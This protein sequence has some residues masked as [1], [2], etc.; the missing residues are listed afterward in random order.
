[1]KRADEEAHIW[2]DKMRHRDETEH[3]AE[4][5]AWMAKPENAAAYARATEEYEFHQG[6]S[7]SRIAAGLSN[8]ATVPGGRRWAFASI[9]AAAIAL[10]FAWLVVGSRHEPQ[11]A[12]VSAATKSMRLT[13]GSR[14]VLSEGGRIETRFTD[15]ERRVILAAGRARFE[16]AHDSSRPFIVVAGGSE[17]VALGTIFEV[18]LLTPQ[19][20]RIALVEGSIEVRGAKDRRALRLRPGETA[21]V[22]DG[23][24]RTLKPAAS[25]QPERIEADGTPLRVVLAQVNQIN[26]VP[27]RLADPALGDLEITGRFEFGKSAALAR[28]FAAALSLDVETTEAG[29]LLRARNQMSLPVKNP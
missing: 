23:S 10:G 21:I 15:G 2:L 22:S 24:P 14:V 4:F 20:P 19:R 11:V 9:L 17:T 18:D 29:L 1:V 8:Q 16:V 28:Q 12:A 5:D 7:T 27:I 13:D 6:L 3:R 25:F 26:A